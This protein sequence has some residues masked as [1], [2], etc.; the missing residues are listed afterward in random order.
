MI[1]PFDSVRRFYDNLNER[2]RK[3]VGLLG[4]VL[5]AFL[6]FLPLYLM[7]SSISELEDD[8][9][10]MTSVLRDISR[11][12]PA[13]RKRQARRKARRELYD[14]RTPQLGT[15]VESKA[16]EQGLTIR[17]VDDQPEKV[18]DNYKR[19][20]TRV[21]LPDVG[22]KPVIEMMAAIENS[23]YPVAIERIHVE[24]FH[25]GDEYNVQLGV[26]AYDHLGSKPDEKSSEAPSGNP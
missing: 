18:I 16:R 13:L 6:V 14:N 12:R 4:G 17:E 19:R 7:S 25:S 5:A 26:V 23:R 15:F 10:E 22:L 9:R 8:N 2:E 24:H 11:A 20:H 1:D 21:T 3:L